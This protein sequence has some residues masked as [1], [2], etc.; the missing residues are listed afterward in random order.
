MFKHKTLFVFGQL[1]L[2][3]G[4]TVEGK[5][6]HAL[7]VGRVVGIGGVGGPLGY[8]YAH[9]AGAVSHEGGHACY[10]GAF[11]FAVGDA[12][13]VVSEFAYAGEQFRVVRLKA[14]PASLR[15]VEAYGG[16]RD[17]VDGNIAEQR[18]QFLGGV[19]CI[20]G[21]MARVPFYVA[22]E[23]ALQVEVADAVASLLVVQHAVH[24]Y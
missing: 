22:Y 6:Y 3:A 11:H 7:Y 4:Q 1:V 13:A 10:G 15:C 21:G 19:Y 5:L 17:A 18:V 16:K 12:S 2:H 20:R 23:T 14:Y 9:R 8:R 24:A